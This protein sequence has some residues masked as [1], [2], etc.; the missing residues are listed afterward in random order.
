MLIGMRA[1]RHTRL[2]TIAITLGLW[3]APAFSVAADQGRE[4]LEKVPPEEYPIYDRVVETKFL[5]SRT[6]LVIIDRLTVGELR[7]DL[8]PPTWEFFTEFDFFAGKLQPETATDFLF[9]TRRRSRLEARFNFGVRYQFVPDGVLEEP[10]VFLA[11]VPAGLTR[12]D[13]TRIGVLGFSRVGFNARE[14][15][16]LVY[17]GDFRSDGSGAG[18]L[19]LLHRVGHEWKITDTEVLWVAREDE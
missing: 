5:T 15:Q 11:P 13:P 8:P 16:A 18:F 12:F 14:D 6:R 17:V 9:K 7:P 1:Q 2:L 3:A 4:K 19:V 10:M